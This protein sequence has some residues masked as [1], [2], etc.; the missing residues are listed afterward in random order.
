V[1]RK[2]T[3]AQAVEERDWLTPR[4]VRRL[5]EQRRIPS[6]RVA[7]RIL[8]DLDELDAYVDGCRVESVDELTA[9]RRRA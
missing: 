7:G 9:R 6:Y 2:V 3:R 1:G 8:V 4:L 5:T